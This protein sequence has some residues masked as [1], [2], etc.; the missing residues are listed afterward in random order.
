MTKENTSV[1]NKTDWSVEKSKE[2]YGVGS[3]G[4]TFFDVNDKGNVVVTPHGPTGPT[5]DLMELTQDLQERGIRVPMLIRFPDITKSRVELLSGCFKK[6]IEDNGFKGS[7]RG[8]YPIKVNQQRHLV[9]ELVKF[10]RNA[11]MGLECGSKPELLVVLAMMNTENALIICNGFKDTEYIETAILSQ[12]LGRN[13]IIVVDRMAELPMIIEAAKKFSILPKIG[14][15][16]KLYTKGA[17]KWID[18]SGDRSKFGLTTLEI[19]EAVELLKKEN[20]LEALELLHFPIGSQIPSI[21]SV[22]GSLKEGARFYT[23]LYGMGARLKYMDVGGGLGVD[24]DGSGA[25]DSSINYSEQEYANDVVS[26]I[27]S[28]C[29]EKGTPHPNIVT[30]CGRA[31]VAHHSVLVFNVL[32]I[33]E[34]QKRAPSVQTSKEDHRVIQDLVYMMDQLNDNNLHE[35]Y[36]DVLHIKETILQLFTFGVLSLQQRAKA[37]NLCWVLLTRME[38]MARANTDTEDIAKSLRETLSDTYFCNFSVFQSMPDSWAVQ[39]M[40]PVLPI[41]RLTE[42]PSRRAILV[43]LTCDSDGKIGQFIDTTGEYA[44]QKKTGLEVHE[45]TG[46]PYYMG[47]FLVGAYQEILGDLHNLF[48]D[49]DAVHISVS[50]AGYSVDE[51]VAGDSVSEVL[52]YVQYNRH[53]LVESIRRASEDSILR[54]TLTKNEAKALMKHYEEGLSGYTYLEDPES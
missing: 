7:Y 37:E 19:V 24:Y 22:K 16:A 9:Q 3:W 36:H 50:S 51:V 46:E 32:G 41:H 54:G 40:F 20:M 25:T 31:L 39:Q 11:T 17:G 29:E 42:E 6:A 12:K 49:T 35:F 23:E 47:V 2:L 14:L 43:D 48:G 21:S 27:Q 44:K 52:S 1:T 45:F 15:R 8:V 26:I 5:V 4:A 18:S 10:G 30:E 33:N 53:E 28:V 34:V 13:T 38:K